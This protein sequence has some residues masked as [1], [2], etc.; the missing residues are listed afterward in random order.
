MDQHKREKTAGTRL[1]VCPSL[2]SDTNGPQLE[3][4]LYSSQL[5]FLVSE[6]AAVLSTMRGPQEIE[7]RGLIFGLGGLDGI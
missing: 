6:A 7:S 3:G 2:T 1:A 4:A 5:A